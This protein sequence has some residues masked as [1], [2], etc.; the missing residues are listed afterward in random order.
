MFPSMVLVIL[1]AQGGRVLVVLNVRVVGLVGH[2]EDGIEHWEGEK[3]T[4]PLTYLKKQS[5]HKFLPFYNHIIPWK[6]KS[7]RK[8]VS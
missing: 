4:T 7:I 8:V 2:G 3:K 6:L 5:N 1:R